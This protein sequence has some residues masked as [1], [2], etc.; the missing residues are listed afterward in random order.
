MTSQLK[1]A[2]LR[3]LMIA[4]PLGALAVLG[5]L[6]AGQGWQGALIAGGIGFFGPIVARGLLEGGWDSHRAATGNVKPG[7]VGALPP[8]P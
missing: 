5:A 1:A 3:A 6:Q 4:G 2:L 8:K 7:D